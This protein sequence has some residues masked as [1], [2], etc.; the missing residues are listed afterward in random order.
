[1]KA[2]MGAVCGLLVLALI[3]AVPAVAPAAMMQLTG[4]VGATLIGLPDIKVDMDGMDPGNDGI[5]VGSGMVFSQAG[6][7]MIPKGET[8]VHD[9]YL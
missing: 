2:R 1:M 5:S 8:E 6:H 3:A 4:T 7:Y 9:L